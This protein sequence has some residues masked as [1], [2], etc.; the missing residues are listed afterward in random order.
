MISGVNRGANVGDDIS[1]SGTVA[2][3]FEAALQGIPGIAVSTF[4]RTTPDFTPAAQV[5]ARLAARCWRMACRLM[6][7]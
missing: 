6:S 5:A 7:S 4:A 2:A 3:A 1:Y